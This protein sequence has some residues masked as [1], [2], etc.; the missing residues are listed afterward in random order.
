MFNQGHQVFTSANLVRNSA[1]DTGILISL[2]V[3]VRYGVKPTKLNSYSLRPLAEWFGTMIRG[4]QD[5]G[6]S[7]ICFASLRVALR[8][9]KHQR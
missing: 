9:V 7:E 5:G 4:T 1:R 6:I 8:L 2:I 3:S